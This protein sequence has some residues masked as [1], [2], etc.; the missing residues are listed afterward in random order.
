MKFKRTDLLLTIIIFI[1]A[2]GLLSFA[3]KPAGYLQNG[4]EIIEKRTW[5]SKT[6]SDGEGHYFTNFAD[7]RIHFWDGFLYQD[8][9]KY[10]WPKIVKNDIV[11]QQKPADLSCEF[12]QFP[13]GSYSLF[14]GI[15][16]ELKNNNISF[17]DA[18]NDLLFQLTAPHSFDAKMNTYENL[19]RIKQDDRKL[20]IWMDVSCDWLN[21]AAYPLIVDVDTNHTVLSTD[22]WVRKPSAGNSACAAAQVANTFSS[23]ATDYNMSIGYST[24]G[25]GNY[26]LRRGFIEFD[27][28]TLAGATLN[29]A[30]VFYKVLSVASTGYVADI[31]LLGSSNGT[32]CWGAAIDLNDWEQCINNE[33]ALFSTIGISDTD[34]T[35]TSANCPT[36]TDNDT[37]AANRTL[38]VST[39][40][41]NTT[42]NTQYKIMH[43][44]ENK[45][46]AL[47]ISTQRFIPIEALDDPD[48]NHFLLYVSYTQPVP[49][50][51][52]LSAFIAVIITLS[53]MIVVGYRRKE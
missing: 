53:A 31:N 32:S 16:P 25:S 28:T 1:L 27:T 22:T 26:Q 5:N 35:C 3:V 23:K 38:N 30:Q 2:F 51:T 49:E 10:V 19:Y 40:G 9:D 48:T 36:E 39:A 29:S 13:V 4:T 43:S 12:K 45:C 34:C 47:G 50:F 33:G 7:G 20:D 11:L 8:L 21:N 17:F 24:N 14:K 6:F 42:G 15:T 41:L 52:F 18:K 37:C 46:T 44:D